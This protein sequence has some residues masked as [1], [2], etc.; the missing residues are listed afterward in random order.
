MVDATP[1]PKDDIVEGL[2][3]DPPANPENKDNQPAN[4]PANPPENP[5]DKDK[6]DEKVNV[7]EI[8]KKTTES[9]MAQV[10]PL[11]T[12]TGN[13][14]SRQREFDRWSQSDDG[15]MFSKYNEFLEKAANDPRYAN[16]PISQLPGVILKPTA[17]SKVLSDA[18]TAADTAAK[19]SRAGG[20][21]G[22]PSGG[23][24]EEETPDYSQKGMSRE[25]FL[26]VAD[27]NK[28]KMRSR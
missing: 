28:R 5:E 4:P 19:D 21:S 9:V 24:G 8:V 18:K 1:E 3:G 2:F 6:K 11:L 27:E 26:K 15:K 16:I 13:N 23:A 22:R 17:Y 20:T 10:K 14:F 12:Q 25:E 7:E